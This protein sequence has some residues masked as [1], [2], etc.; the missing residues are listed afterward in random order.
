MRAQRQRRG[1]TLQ[2]YLVPSDTHRSHRT[3]VGS[4]EDRSIVE[5][6][7]STLNKKGF[8]FL[9]AAALRI[10]VEGACC[11]DRPPKGRS[12]TVAHPTA[13]GVPLP[14]QPMFAPSMV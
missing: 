7:R 8:T 4:V 1:H 5:P 14:Q 10:N 11:G 3:A 6:I 13:S 2:C 12:L 9:E